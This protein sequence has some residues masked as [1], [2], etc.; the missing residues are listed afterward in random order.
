MTIYIATAVGAS[1]LFLLW[2]I[3][4]VFR[5]S[6]GGGIMREIA[7]SIRKGADAFLKRELKALSVVLAIIAISLFAVNKA[8]ALSFLAGALISALTGVIGMKVATSANVRT[9]EALKTS[10][11]DG[12]K[13]AFSGGAVMGTY[14]DAKTFANLRQAFSKIN[15]QRCSTR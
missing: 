1:F 3:R 11:S 5:Q 4:Y 6:D 13:I 14:P 2:T 7:E 10:F 15:C 9:A 12:F 8:E